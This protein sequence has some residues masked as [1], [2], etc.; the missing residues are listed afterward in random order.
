MD[1][2]EAWVAAFTGGQ[3]H[4]DH[5]AS[6]GVADTASLAIRSRAGGLIRLVLAGELPGAVMNTNNGNVVLKESAFHAA[7]LTPLVA[8]EP[9]IGFRPADFA[10]VV[11][12]LGF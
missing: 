1:F 10:H 7:A 8:L 5:P 9:G 3:R 6:H 4:T 12:D 11:R 2:V